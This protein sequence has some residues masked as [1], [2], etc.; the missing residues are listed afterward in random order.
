M[1]SRI[2]PDVV[3]ERAELGAFQWAQRDTIAAK[4]L[5]DRDVIAGI[6]A[7]LEANLDGLRIAG[8]AAWP[9]LIEQFEDY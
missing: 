9:F 6:D 4:G 7:R 2:V 3:R 1:T 8:P 5:P